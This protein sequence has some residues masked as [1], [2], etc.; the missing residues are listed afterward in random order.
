MMLV[1]LINRLNVT[2]HLKDLWSYKHKKPL[3]DLRK[4]WASMNGNFCSFHLFEVLCL[5]L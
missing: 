1:A 5:S 3:F 4:L 2:L